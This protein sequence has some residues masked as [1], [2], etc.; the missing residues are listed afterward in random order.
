MSEPTQQET[1]HDEPDALPGAFADHEKS[2]GGDNT[3]CST[4]DAGL[5]SDVEI[6]IPSS[7]EKGVLLAE[8]DDEGEY[9][10]NWLHVHEEVV[11]ADG[12]DEDV[13]SNGDPDSSSD[14]DASSVSSTPTEVDDRLRQN[15]IQARID[16]ERELRCQ[17]QARLAQEGRDRQDD[18]FRRRSAA[19][20]EKQRREPVPWHRNPGRLRDP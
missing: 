10:E 12:E 7:G 18:E 2:L 9:L 17:R 19:W 5:Q 13:A 6:T 20:E 8:N 15:R 1:P 14:D 16:E 3:I 11:S 4:D